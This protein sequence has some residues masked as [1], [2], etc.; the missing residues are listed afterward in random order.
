MVLVQLFWYMVLKGTMEIKF[1]IIIMI[2]YYD[3]QEGA[4]MQSPCSE[5]RYTVGAWSQTRPAVLF[6]GR[7][8]GHM[9]VWDLLEKSHEAS[10][11]QDVST[12]SLTCI[13]PC[14][15]SCELYWTAALLVLP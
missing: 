7:E 6:L 13:K 10:E 5:Q 9:E 1:I 8:D 15:F 4:L 12:H 14:L 11:V 2:M 3:P